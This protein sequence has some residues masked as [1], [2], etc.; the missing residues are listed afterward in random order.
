MLKRLSLLALVGACQ[1]GKEKS[2]N[3]ATQGPV[4]VFAAGSLARPMRAALDSFTAATGIPYT[5]ESAGSLELARKFTDLGKGADILA[6]ADEDVFPRL[7][8]PE[9]VAW[10]ARF[11]RNRLVLAYSAS[12][13]GLD[14]AKA[15][16]W[17]RVLTRPGVEVGRAD[18][19][20]DPAGYRTL[21]LFQLAERFYGEP[22]L[23]AKLEAYAPRRHVRPKSAELVALLQAGE[24]DYAWMYESSA[25]GA[26]LS[27]L[28]LPPEVD[29]GRESM[30]ARYD[31][32][33]VRVLGARM[34]DT[35]EV[36][37]TPIRYGLSIPRRAEHAAVA[38]SFL[39]FLF[40]DAGRRALRGEFL[41]VIDTPLLVGEHMPAAVLELA[42]PAAGK[43]TPD[44]APSD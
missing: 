20:L 25:R 30:A 12:A 1:G 3:A 21:L 22:G 34:G 9:H 17:R 36:R 15:G 14:E 10:Y 5:L 38:E 42:A 19:A 41:D 32:A 24:L 6:L 16:A 43:P 33:R 13:T 35:I 28:A 31:S 26:R 11:A 18:P 27:F 39:R 23:A 37:G 40:S 7:L 4:V 2:P 29:L 44:S 8:M